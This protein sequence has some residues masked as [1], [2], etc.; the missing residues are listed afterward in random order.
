MIDV[1]VIETSSL[2]DRSY[3]AHD[4]EVAV[5]V[6]PQRDVDRVL[7]AATDADVR[8]SHVLETH[9]H[10]DY[11]TG[12]LDLARLT[13]A[14]YG[15]SDQD[16]AAFPHL[17]IGDGEVLRVSGVMRIR[18]MA[19]P[20]HTFHHLAYVL[21]DVLEGDGPEGVF[22]GG[23]L[24]YGTTGRTDLLGTDNAEPLARAQHRSA[25]RLADALP[26][27]VR[28]W[29][30]HGFGSF[31]SVGAANVDGST[32]GQERLGNPVL[33]LAEEEF[34]EETLRGLDEYPAYYVHMAPLNLQ[35]P[36]PLDLT[37]PAPADAAELRRRIADGEWVVDLRSRKAYASSHLAGTISLGLNGPMATWL[38]WLLDWG[39]PVTLLADD[40]ED[41]AAA[42]RELVRIGINPV[43]GATGGPARWAEDPQ[44][45]ASLPTATFADYAA[46]RHGGSAGRLPAPEVVLDVRM[47]SEWRTD[48]VE[49]ALHIPLP[50]LRD[51][52]AD[53]PAATVW[54]HCSSGYRAAAAASLL[55]RAG[56]DAVL[57]DDL[58]ANAEEAGVP[59]TRE[60]AAAGGR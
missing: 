3:L 4:G 33:R 7:E 24:L 44:Q 19:T 54:V 39:A 9:I 60:A 32:L 40:P 59:L 17:G 1:T 6:D 10:N 49:G 30:T 22:T 5:V 46:F 29:P 42:R 57:I 8:I 13:G 47:D 45:L 36:A 48:H 52:M 34:V 27:G 20:G 58:Y 25:R 38:G 12:G 18:A 15:L 55:A 43:A 2:G 56:R 11:I 37:G 53:L 14:T 50:R 26:D 31:C 51:R 16:N 41:V 28:I 21:E 23:S 35:G